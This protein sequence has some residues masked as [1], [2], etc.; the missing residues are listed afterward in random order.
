MG[1]IFRNVFG[2]YLS[3]VGLGET[4]FGHFN[5]HLRMMVVVG[6]AL[7]A[8]SIGSLV[9]R[10]ELMESLSI[11]DNLI[12]ARSSLLDLLPSPRRPLHTIS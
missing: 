2:L 10:Y 12:R 1:G 6:T 5:M 9:Y 4:S 8:F 3:R 11:V 7:Y